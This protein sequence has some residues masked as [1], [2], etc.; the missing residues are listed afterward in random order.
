MERNRS[1]D[2]Q[3]VPWIIKEY[4]Y[5]TVLLHEDQRYLG[6]AVVWLV[7]EGTMQRFSEITE[8]EY[9][10]LKKVMREYETVLNRLWQPDF[11]N[12]LWL[13]NLF[14]MH[15]GHGH[16]HLVPRYKD[17]RIFADT[18]FTDGRW[19][20]NYTPHEDFKPPEDVLI[21]IR[22]ALRDLM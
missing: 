21:Q 10:E 12:Y 22:D 3:Y 8:E 1:I 17:E 7:R 6:R 9:L 16:L 18:S 15:G 11:M 4:R 2:P 5:W 19:G 20:K 13:A 14:D